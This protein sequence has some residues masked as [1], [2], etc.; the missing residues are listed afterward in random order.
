MAAQEYR[1]GIE[2]RKLAGVVVFA[3]VGVELVALAAAK[4][5]VEKAS[6]EVA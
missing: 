4:Q 1:N 3:I 6:A 2:R 5:P